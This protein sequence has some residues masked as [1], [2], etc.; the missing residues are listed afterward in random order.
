MDEPLTKIAPHD[1]TLRTLSQTTVA[2]RAV[3]RQVKPMAEERFEFVAGHKPGTLRIV[4]RGFWDGDAVD[5]YLAALRQ[6]AAMTAR[7]SSINRVLLDMKA[8][9]VQSQTVMNSFMKII[10][11]YAAQISEYGVLLPES[12]LL[13]LQMERLMRD[14]P[15]VFF[16]EESQALQ[17]LAS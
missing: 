13:K 8:C 6:R 7:P 15:A 17:W 16:S 9:T 11:N 1:L 10:I 5:S 3:I 4:F 2:Q 12:A 14:T